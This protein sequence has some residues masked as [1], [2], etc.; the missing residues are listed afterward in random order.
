MYTSP[1]TPPC[2]EALNQNNCELNFSSLGDLFK[3]AE[4][5]ADGERMPELQ[6]L[7]YH[8]TPKN[9]VGD[10]RFANKRKSATKDSSNQEQ[11]TDTSIRIARIAKKNPV[12]YADPTVNE[13][14]DDFRERYLTLIYRSV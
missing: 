6:S 14:Y 13:L 11:K 9:K 1:H 3:L 8:E 4:A 5:S 10:A 7:N 2:H 12:N